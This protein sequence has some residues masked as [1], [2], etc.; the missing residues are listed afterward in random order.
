MILYIFIGVLIGAIISFTIC[1]IMVKN[2]NKR[3]M[4]GE[5]FL[6]EPDEDSEDPY[7]FLELNTEPSSLLDMDHVYMKVRKKKAPQ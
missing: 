3:F 5:L 4:V 1:T 6:I 2:S 7:L